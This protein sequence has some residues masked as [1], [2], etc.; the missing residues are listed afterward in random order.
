MKFITIVIP[1]II[2]STA[3]AQHGMAER[4]GLYNFPYHGDTWTGIVTSLDPSTRHLTLSYSHKDKSESFTGVLQAEGAALEDD[5]GNAIANQPLTI[6]QKLMVYYVEK[7]RKYFIWDDSKKKH[8]AKA[9]EN[10]IFKIRLFRS[11]KKH[12]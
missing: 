7:G 8:E 2:V 3:I 5:D 1:L 11:D 12:S 9:D 10:I 6:G 4:A